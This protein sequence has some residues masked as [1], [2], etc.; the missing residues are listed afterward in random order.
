MMQQMMSNPALMSMMMNPA[1]NP[2]GGGSMVAPLLKMLLL[3]E[4]TG[5]Y[6]AGA[7]LAQAPAQ[8]PEP[9]AEMR[10]QRARFASQL[11]QL[12]AMGFTNEAACLRA[13][14]Q[15]EGRLD[16]AIDTLLSGDGNNP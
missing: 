5:G 16:A 15:H 6:A 10:L 14:A 1:M 3:T 8:T 13:L 11:T 9:D 4:G 12:S 2:F 7:P